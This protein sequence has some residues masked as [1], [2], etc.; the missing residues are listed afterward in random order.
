[1]SLGHPHHLRAVRHW[2]LFVIAA[3]VATVFAGIGIYGTLRMPSSVT[4]GFNYGYRGAALETATAVDGS[5]AVVAG[6]RIV[7]VAG[8]ALTNM[9][10]LHDRLA[11]IGNGRQVE[12]TVE[13]ASGRQRTVVTITRPPENLW[14]S[15]LMLVVGVLYL[16]TPL[17]LFWFHPGRSESWG[18]LW[19]SLSIGVAFCCFAAS[20]RT[21]QPLI[22]VQAGLTALGL[23]GALGFHL[24]ATFPRPLPFVRRRPWFPWAIDGVMGLIAA[25]AAALYLHRQALPPLF[26]A[27]IVANLLL[28]GAIVLVLIWR[29]RRP[30]SPEDAARLRALMVAAAIAF[31]FP[32]LLLVLRSAGVAPIPLDL[33][34]LASIACLLVF[35]LLV[36][37]AVFR[38][39][40][41]R[42][43][44]AV[45]KTA[46]YSGAFLLLS[47]SVAGTALVTSTILAPTAGGLTL[48]FVAI[49][50]ASALRPLQKRAEQ[51]LVRCFARQRAPA[52]DQ[53]LE[54]FRAALAGISRRS[55]Q[56]FAHF[57][58][59]VE[60]HLDVKLA[61]LLIPAQPGEWMCPSQE[62]GPVDPET[63]LTGHKVKRV[64]LTTGGGQTVGQLL[65]VHSSLS[66]SSLPILRHLEREATAA[67]SSLA[68]GEFVGPFRV[69]RFLAAGG[70][71]TIYLAHREGAGGFRKQVVV[72]RLLPTL[73]GKNE[74][75]ERFLTEARIVAKLSHPNVANVYEVG[76]ADSGFYIAMEYVD[77]CDVSQLIRHCRSRGELVPVPI[78]VYIATCI[79]RGLAH[80]H[81][82]V[83][84]NGR[85]LGLIHQ[86]VTPH[87]VLLSRQGA[88]KLTDFGV[89]HAG[90]KPDPE[91]LVGKV[92]YMS[93]EQI[94]G[95]SFDQR[96]DV[97]A[98]GIVLY[99]ML[100]NEH[101]FRGNDRWAIWAAI[102]AGR[103]QPAEVFRDLSFD[104]N[105]IVDRAL[106]TAVED[107]FES[108]HAMAAA[109]E[110]LQSLHSSHELAVAELV[111]AAA[112]T[113]PDG[114]DAASSGEL[115][116]VPIRSPSS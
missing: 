8:E 48:V 32:A 14:T 5:D 115:D 101:P 97:F 18:F 85:P 51:V 68:A 95:A 28:A 6:E 49:G 63:L 31:P 79:C 44:H 76:E 9:A 21:V 13:D 11:H 71:G 75:V 104:L 22:V 42:I 24:F 91:V 72:K 78:A 50:V 10:T 77:G 53:I 25:S 65:L 86:D 108:A 96:V 38:F 36:G 89:A 69:E 54:I 70:M 2:W 106:A 20:P 60:T 34:R 94:D 64:L 110:E 27:L 33:D 35:P 56:A 40:L 100:T 16:A 3:A 113:Q 107:R 26:W 67:L 57:E 81:S 37:R 30:Q 17:I 39:D 102:S 66:T 61:R 46:A 92:P 59:L 43:D 83:D 23:Q 62:A 29:Y 114:A 4:P 90:G 82:C 99:E 109:L 98:T 80:A 116:T 12:L 41:L 7:G 55:P 103:Y 19:F 111:E 74:V 87:N 58:R 52:I 84:A 88:V 73:E 15:W 47:A 1:M 93:P 112:Q 105:D 45:A